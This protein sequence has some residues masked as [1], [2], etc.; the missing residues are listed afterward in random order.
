MTWWRLCAFLEEDTFWSFKIERWSPTNFLLSDKNFSW[1]TNWWQRRLELAAHKCNAKLM[2]RLRLTAAN[3]IF[4]ADRLIVVMY[5]R[6]VWMINQSITDILYRAISH[7]YYQINMLA[8]FN[9]VT[10]A[11]QTAGVTPCPHICRPFWG[12]KPCSASV[13]PLSVPVTV[14]S[15]SVWVCARWNRGTLSEENI[16]TDRCG[17]GRR[18]L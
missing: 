9:G 8:W 5:V 11:M 13:C 3:V 7:G 2:W 18:G 1:L 12:F 6:N 16:N 17:Y 14:N 15:E 4:I 10:L